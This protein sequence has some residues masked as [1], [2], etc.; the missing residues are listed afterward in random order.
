MPQDLIAVGDVMLDGA[1]P[2]PVAGRRSPRPDRRCGP[3]GPPPTRRSRRDA[4]VRER[5]GRRP[6]RS[7]RCRPAGLRRTGRRR[8]RVAARPRRRMRRPARV[9]VFGGSTVVADPGASAR[10]VPDDVPD[11]ARRQAR[12]SSPATRSCRPGPRRLRGRR[13]SARGPAG[14]PSTRPRRTW[15]PRSAST[16][17]SQ[18]RRRSTSLLANAEEAFALTG[19]EGEEAALEL[20]PTVPR[21]LRQAREPGRCRRIRG[22]HGPRRRATDRGRKHTRRG[23]LLRGRAAARPRRRRRARRRGAGRLRHR[24]RC[25]GARGRD[26]FP[27]MTSVALI[28]TT[29]SSPAASSRCSA[30]PRV[31]AATTV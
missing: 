17:S 22:H 19:R 13:S 26:Y 4:S 30:L 24:D 10:L 14:S 2:M 11:D 20:A 23:R 18:R 16:D 29:T 1:L 15:S 12:S 3:V 9:V 31:I 8:R 21:R 7:R 5:G 28:R 6:H 25:L 27:S